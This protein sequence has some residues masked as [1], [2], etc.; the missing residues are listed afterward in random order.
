MTLKVTFEIGSLFGKVLKTL[1]LRKI[2]QDDQKCEIITAFG[3]ILSPYCIFK[4]T[5]YWISECLH[6]KLEFGISQFLTIFLLS[7][8]SW[9]EPLLLAFL[10]LHIWWLNFNSAW[11]FHALPPISSE[12]FHILCIYFSPLPKCSVFHG[13]QYFSTH[14][15]R[16]VKWIVFKVYTCNV[17]RI[18]NI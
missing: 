5:H 2:R 11:I 9:V 3:I 8:L 6:L 14:C 13:E 1:F 18:W 7:S 16:V 4:Y 10:I 12:H 17:L 15:G